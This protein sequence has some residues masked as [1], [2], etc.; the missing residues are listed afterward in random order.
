MILKVYSI[1]DSVVGAYLQP[2]F[3]RSEAEAVRMVKQAVNDP[4]TNFHKHNAD[5]CLAFHGDYDDATGDFSTGPAQRLVV[6][7][8]LVDPYNPQ[9]PKI[10][11][12]AL[13]AFFPDKPDVTN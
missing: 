10:D 7:S 9:P 4:S 5:F 13:K 2:F 11:P 1:Y 6:L 3:C 8:S 12:E